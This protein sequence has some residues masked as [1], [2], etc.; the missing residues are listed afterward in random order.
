MK[1]G[2]AKMSESWKVDSNEL[3]KKMNVTEK[4]LSD[5]Q[6]LQ[7]REKVGENLLE[8]AKKKSV[9]QVFLSQFCDLLVIILIIAAVISAFSENPE[10]TIVI[11]A[12]LIMN[13]ILGTVQH[14]KA[15]KSLESLKQLSSPSAKIMRN[16][17]KI[18]IPSK[19]VV[20]GDILV[21]EAGDLI[22]ADGRIINNYSLQVNESSLT[23]ES[24]NVEKTDK[25]LEGDIP[26]ADRINM[27]YSGSLVVYGR[28]E[29][30]VTETGMNTEIG[31]IAGLMN[32]AKER[33]TPLQKSL[34]QFSGRLA[35]GIMIISAVVFV[36]CL[37]RNVSLI[38]SLMFAVALAVAAIPEALGSIVTIVQA[39]G[40]GR[41]ASDF[42]F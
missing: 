29:V 12:V 34:D 1:N 18:Q 31:K 4:G 11:I 5:E 25:A 16:G 22:V 3:M 32:K 40:T 8:E 36:L 20:P 30:L 17:I 10:S 39:I 42:F 28:A 35:I 24:T 41:M 13:S 26:L 9:L 14:I 37:I 19:E 7:I 27:V 38:D 15:E 23:G 21:L 2:G 33:K 6:V